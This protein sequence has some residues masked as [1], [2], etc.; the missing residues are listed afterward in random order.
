MIL[1]L[2]MKSSGWQQDKWTTPD[3]FRWAVYVVIDG[4]EVWRN[5]EFFRD[6]FN[7]K[8]SAK[9]WVEGN[10]KHLNNTKLELEEQLIIE[11]G[12]D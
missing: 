5:G 6:G 3:G 12:R 7:D 9:W 1:N 2:I 11:L 10:W 8:N 4:V